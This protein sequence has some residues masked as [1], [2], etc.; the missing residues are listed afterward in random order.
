M[1]RAAAGRARVKRGSSD[2]ATFMRKVAEP[3]RKRSMCARKSGGRSV[4]AE[5]REEQQLRPDVGGDRRGLEHAAVL[6]LDAGGARR[7]RR[8]RRQHAP[9]RR[10]ALR[11]ARRG[12]RASRAIAVVI[13]PMPPMA[14]PQTPRLA[15]DLAEGVVQQHVAAAGR[16]GAARSCRPPSRSRA[17]PSA[18]SPSNQWSSSSPALRVNSSCTSRCVASGSARNWRPNDSVA[19]RS[20][21][22]AQV[23][24]RRAQQQAAQQL[25][26]ALEHRVVV[27]QAR[28]VA[29]AEAARLGERV[30]ER[31]AGAERVAA[32]QRQE[33]LHRALDDAQAV[34]GE[35]QVADHARVEQADGV[36]GGGV[37][38]A[39]ME[40]LGDGGAADDV[41]ALEDSDLEA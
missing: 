36:A 15:V 31:R 35:P 6:E 5:H 9:H 41:A 39:G 3:K 7:R 30:G 14:W 38:E 40:F 26:G 2:S 24:R 13:A 32:G 10:V 25:H 33:V 16:V 21:Q 22:A 34:F 17:A 1:R 20:P 19:H 29:G 4:G 28:G 11:R 18:A 8:A 23:G 27:G 12:A 37:A